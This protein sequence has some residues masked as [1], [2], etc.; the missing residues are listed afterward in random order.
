MRDFDIYIFK[1]YP[2]DQLVFYLHCCVMRFP[3]SSL[4]SKM[5]YLRSAKEKNIK[6]REHPPGRV[7]AR[8]SLLSRNGAGDPWKGPQPPGYS[9]IAFVWRGPW[10]RVIASH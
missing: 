8:F 4:S 10:S 3:C 6:V 5:S 7:S 9:S 1:I 2:T